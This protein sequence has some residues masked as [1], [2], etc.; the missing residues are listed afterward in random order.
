[1]KT[2]GSSFLDAL[3]SKGYVKVVGGQVMLPQFHF[4]S[5]CLKFESAPP[6]LLPQSKLI[7]YE[8]SMCIYYL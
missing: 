3:T 1:M 4:L 5:A 2:C 7:S 8:K 6:I